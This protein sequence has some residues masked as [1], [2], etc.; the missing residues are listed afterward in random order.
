M[1]P[2]I[3]DSRSSHHKLSQDMNVNDGLVFGRSEY[4]NKGEGIYAAIMLE[5]NTYML[6]YSDNYPLEAESNE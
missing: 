5:S 4:T 6:K 3:L 2:I 1:L